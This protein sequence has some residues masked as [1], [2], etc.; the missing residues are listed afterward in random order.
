MP[1]SLVRLAVFRLFPVY[2]KL[3]QNA[4]GKSRRGRNKPPGGGHDRAPGRIGLP[5]VITMKKQAWKTYVFWIV[6]A[7]AVGALAGWLT[8]GGAELYRRGI[9]RPPLSPPGIVFPI[10]WVVLYALMGVGAARVRLTPPSRERTRAL[11]VFLLQLAVNFLWPILF[12]GL[13]SF[14]LALLWLAALWGLVLWMMSAFS[15]VDLPAARLQFPYF[16]W[17]TFAAYLNFGVWRLNG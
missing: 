11:E 8:R 5:G 4:R 14:G 10:V 15:Q 2:P 1:T 13:Q 16:L 17:V 7:E 6:L 12:F 9:T 3:R